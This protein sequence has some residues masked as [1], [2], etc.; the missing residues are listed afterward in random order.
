V[1]QVTVIVTASVTATIK[2]LTMTPQGSNVQSTLTNS[3]GVA[4]TDPFLRDER[5]NPFWVV[6]LGR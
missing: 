6:L 4:W 5:S 3:I 1:E 2:A